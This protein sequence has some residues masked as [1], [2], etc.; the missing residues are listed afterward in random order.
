MSLFCSAPWNGPYFPHYTESLPQ[1]WN[2]ISY[3]PVPRRAPLNLAASLFSPQTPQAVALASPLPGMLFP[4]TSPWL[5]LSS[6]SILY[7]S[8]AFSRGPTLRPH[9][10]LQP[11]HR[12]WAPYS[13]LLY[14]SPTGYIQVATHSSILLGESHGQRSLLGYSPWGRKRNWHNL[15][16][17]QQQTCYVG[18]PGSSVAKNLPANAGDTDLIPGSERSLG[19]GNGRILACKIMER[20]AWQAAVHGVTKSQT[21]LSD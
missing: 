11:P 12:S 2:L 10:K 17:K 13:A 4:L 20:G 1:L 21:Q 19:E 6:A 8:A 7:F 3:C 18:F 16:T 5:P 14:L 15:S 9:L